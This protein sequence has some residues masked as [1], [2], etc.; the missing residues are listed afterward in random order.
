[1]ADLKALLELLLQASITRRNVE[2]RRVP[3]ATITG[4]NNIGLAVVTVRSLP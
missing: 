3:D 2:R 1:M 4:L